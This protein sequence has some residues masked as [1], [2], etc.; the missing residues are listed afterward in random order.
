MTSTASFA[1]AFTVCVFCGANPGVSPQYQ[2]AARD[3]AGLFHKNNW[4]L[5]YGGGTVGLMGALSS[6]LV[7]LSGPTSVHGIIPRPLIKFEQS[8]SVPPADEYGTTTIVEDM[9]ARKAMMGRLSKAF[10][11][12]PGGFGTME[13]FFEVVTWNQLGIHDCPVVVL[14]IEGFYDGLLGWVVKATEE[15]FIK[16]NLRGIIV[17]AKTVDEIETAIRT[18]MPV[19]GRFDLDWTSEGK[20]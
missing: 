3:L 11:V 16:S 18:Y 1:D 12:M 15:G 9:H 2:Q 6:T 7:S 8:G 14:N 10:I 5:V 19:E 17:E 4:N 13:E 20:D